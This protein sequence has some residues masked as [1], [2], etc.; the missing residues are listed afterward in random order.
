MLVVCYREVGHMV[1]HYRK[2]FTLPLNGSYLPHDSIFKDI[3][4]THPVIR[5]VQLNH[6][7]I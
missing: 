4:C 1:R 6:S 2:L 7:E 3:N 5:G